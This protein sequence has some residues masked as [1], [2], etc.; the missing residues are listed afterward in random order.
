MSRPKRFSR[1]DESRPTRTCAVVTRGASSNAVRQS[2]AKAA[3]RV[4]DTRDGNDAKPYAASVRDRVP[5]EMTRRER[6]APR[7]LVVDAA[8]VLEKLLRERIDVIDV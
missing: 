7:K 4:T 8:H 1:V 6:D 2:D 5:G 3:H